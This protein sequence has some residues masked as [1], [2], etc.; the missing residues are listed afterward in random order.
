MEAQSFDLSP[1]PP[2]LRHGLAAV[3]AFS[4]LSFIS[5]AALIV[6]LAYKLVSWQVRR[7]QPTVT[8]SPQTPKSELFDHNGFLVPARRRL[9]ISSMPGETRDESFW[10]RLRREPPNQFLILIL[11]LFLADTQQALA[12]MLSV[13]WIVRDGV[14]SGSSTCWAQG[15]FVSNGDLASSVFITA[16]ALHTYLGLVRGCRL[17]SWAFYWAVGSLWVF[18]F[19]INFLAVLVTDN[20]NGDGGLF[21]LAGAWVSLQMSKESL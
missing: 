18:V 15:W 19:L 7:S 16:I 10:A 9:S 12:F 13:D 8:R 17:P 3:A 4:L 5:G 6:F 14:E 1:L 11:N 20:G 21:V 2:A